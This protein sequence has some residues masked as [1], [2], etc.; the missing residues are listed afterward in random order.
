MYK[1]NYLF[2]MNI[3]GEIFEIKSCIEMMANDIEIDTPN[4]YVLQL[5]KNYKIYILEDLHP[6]R[7]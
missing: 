6:L 5:I 1:R 2:R 4:Q 7:G 3:I